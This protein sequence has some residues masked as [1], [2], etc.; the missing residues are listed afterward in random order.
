MFFYPHIPECIGWDDAGRSVCRCYHPRPVRVRRILAEPDRQ[1][2]IYRRTSRGPYTL[3]HRA[4]SFVGVLAIL[5]L[6]TK[7]P[8]PRDT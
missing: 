2:H 5:D 1:W 7:A 4:D 6:V 3:H 8:E